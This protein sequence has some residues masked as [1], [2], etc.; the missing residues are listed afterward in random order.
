MVRLRRE[1]ACRHGAVAVS[2]P[3]DRCSYASICSGSSVQ[4]RSLSR[5]STHCNNT[6]LSRAKASM[7]CVSLAVEGWAFADAMSRFTM[8]RY[9][10]S[11]SSK[12]ITGDSTGRSAEG[13][14]VA[15]R[16]CLGRST[17]KFESPEWTGRGPSSLA[18]RASVLLTKAD[19]SRPESLPT[20]ESDKW[21]D[22]NMCEDLNMLKR[23]YNKSRLRWLCRMCGSRRMDSSFI[24]ARRV[25]DRCNDTAFRA[26]LPF[27]LSCRQIPAVRR[28][29]RWHPRRPTSAR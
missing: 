25:A 26:A 18:E 10:R 20:A 8:A 21:L 3:V 4:S 13:R 2:G 15:E 6:A 17:S 24:S 28:Q 16:P 7:R 1:E 19:R 11:Q 12:A 23:L 27:S 9:R 22:G 5:S 14:P 29:S